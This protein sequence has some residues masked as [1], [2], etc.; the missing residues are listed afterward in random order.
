VTAGCSVLAPKN[1]GNGYWYD[2]AT[3]LLVVEHSVSGS[4][5]VVG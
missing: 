1:S 3:G 2:T 4:V 5:H